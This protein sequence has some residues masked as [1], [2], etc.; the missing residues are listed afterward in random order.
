MISLQEAIFQR[1]SR[2][3]YLPAPIESA[4]KSALVSA[5]EQCNRESGLSMQFVENGG[6]A[7]NGLAKSYGMF[8]G[9]R[10][11]IVM[12]G[13]KKD[14][15]MEEKIG[16]MGEHIVL[17]ATRLHL[18]TCWVGASFDKNNPIFDI[19]EDEKMVCVVPVGNVQPDKTVREKFIRRMSHGKTKPQEH[20]YIA[21]AVLPDWFLKAIAAVQVAPSAVNRQKYKFIFA[22]GAVEAV[23]NDTSQFAMI[24][25]GIAKA[26]FV[27]AAD[28]KFE[29]GNH[30]F[31]TK[32]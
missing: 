29:W 6:D 22:N 18:G 15:N 13:D 7:F 19:G 31:Y 17:E 9:V 24:D 3:N 1:T 32:P 30:A 16:F 27:I 23:S 8:S 12:K 2:R 21:D 28:G 10:S 11:L 26:H 20:F 25:L 5:I 14:V 4:K